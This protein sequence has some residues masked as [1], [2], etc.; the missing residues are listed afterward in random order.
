MIFQRKRIIFELAWLK[1]LVSNYLDNEAL[2]FI[3][4]EEGR[5]VRLIQD[6]NIFTKKFLEIKC[7][8]ECMEE[9]EVLETYT[10]NIQIN[11]PSDIYNA[12]N[13]FDYYFYVD[14]NTS[15]NPFS[16]S[17]QQRKENIKSIIELYSLMIYTVLNKEDEDEFDSTHPKEMYML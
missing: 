8:K 1:Y 2:H 4:Q 10:K 3:L 5:Y 16:R 14:E 15:E 17:Y 11:T 12:S 13:F 9:K 6:I 7:D